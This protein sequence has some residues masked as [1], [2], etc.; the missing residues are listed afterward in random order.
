MRA[1][2]R[3]GLGIVAATL[4][5]LSGCSHDST[6]RERRP[7]ILVV[8]DTLRADHLGTYGYT[9]AT[10]PH[11]DDWARSGRLYERAF[12]TSPWTAPSFGSIFTGQLPS[13]HGVMRQERPDGSVLF[14]SLDSGSVPVAE[15]LSANGYRTA[16][17]VNNPFLSPEFGL[18]RGFDL[19]DYSPGDNRE[20]RPAG[21]M[22]DRTLEWIDAQ[23]STSFFVVMQLF[24]PHL[25][26]DAPSPFRG[27]F[28]DT[29]DSEWELPVGEMNAI[30]SQAAEL[31]AGDR[32]FIEAAYDEEVAYVDEQLGRFR[33]ALAD[34]GLLDGSLV[35][36]TS[37]HGEEFFEHGGFEH[38][39]ALWQELVHVPLVAWGPGVVAGRDPSP[40]SIV[41]LAPTVLEFAGLAPVPSTAGV[42]LWPS[43]SASGELPERTLYA[44][45]NLYGTEL[46][47]AI[48][49][50]FK[51]IVS[52]ESGGRFLFDLEANPEERFVDLPEQQERA[53]SM[54]G[55]LSRRVGEDLAA[56][57]GDSPV[58]LDEET[59]EKLRSMGYV[60]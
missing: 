46:K 33:Q 49:W 8:V 32:S 39:H 42:T 36:L 45:Q 2:A 12:A 37:D 4:L 20:I 43:L 30:R 41:D 40:A 29:I 28:T 27:R 26:Y 54:L 24:D 1:G 14:G 58:A 51:L 38:G 55:E 16:A 59:L 57:E 31:T 18:D 19:Y 10:S 52:V 5:M 11:L 15:R 34:R 47:A 3:T 7:V 25:D 44:E 48:R 22:V 35:L 53:Q 23:A 56:R 21:A 50:P 60:R 6:E 17:F 13:R 9:R